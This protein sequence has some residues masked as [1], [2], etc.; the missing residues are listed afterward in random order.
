M[1]TNFLRL[2]ACVGL[3]AGA[4]TS[5]SAASESGGYSCSSTKSAKACTATEAEAG[6][7]KGGA[8][9]KGAT[10]KG[11][12]CAKACAETEAAAGMSK[13]GA[14]DK[15]VT[16]PAFAIGSTVSNFTYPDTNGKDVS[17][18][19]YKGKIVALVFYNQGCPYVVEV[20][21]RLSEFTKA[22]ADKGVAVLA[23]DAG[24][25]NKSDA[26]KEYAAGVPFPILVNKNSDLAVAAG[27]TRTPEV[28]LI[29]KEGKVAYRGAFDNG[30][31]GSEQGKRASYTEDAVKALLDGKEPAVTQ[32]KAFGCTIKFAKK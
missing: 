28:I 24:V 21:D 31:V 4:T 17:L 2:T 19:D 9:D 20:K 14:A 32:T 23:V 5:V 22:Y 27:A 11:E 3:L 12:S 15:T 8:A 26:I 13:G 7:A 30:E 10:T 1:I 25:N 16:A 18:A 6:M 29:N